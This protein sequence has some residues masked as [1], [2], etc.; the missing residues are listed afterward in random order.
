MESSD[1]MRIDRRSKTLREL[2]LEKLRDG[3]L[4][5]YFRPGDRL[6]ERNLCEQLGVSRTVV[7]EVLRHLET[8]GLVQ[9]IP[10]H[11]PVVARPDRSKAA[12]IYEIRGLLESEAART[13]AKC[14]TPRDIARLKSAIENNELAFAKGNVSE[15]LKGTTAFYEALFTCAGKEVAWDLVKLLNARINQLRSMTI[16]TPG[17]GKSAIE[18]MRRIVAAIELG[19]GDEAYRASMVHVKAV[20]TL[21]LAAIAEQE[22]SDPSDTFGRQ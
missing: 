2:A 15:V 18:E 12:Q 22:K 13:C 9:S 19:D 4:N 3:I 8:E 16:S 14:A 21:A 6:V 17:R 1:Q 20:S 11:G 5:F 7:R 10:H